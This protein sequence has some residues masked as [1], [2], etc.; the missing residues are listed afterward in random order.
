MTDILKWVYKTRR[1]SY[2]R[3]V[4]HSSITESL[5]GRVVDDR[6]VLNVPKAQK[7]RHAHLVIR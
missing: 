7:L 6:L 5:T 3:V 2:L 4:F 1:K